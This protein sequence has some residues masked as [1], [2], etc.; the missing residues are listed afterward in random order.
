MH[1]LLAPKVSMILFA[2]LRGSWWSLEPYEVA[3][4]RH[5]SSVLQMKNTSDVQTDGAVGY[6]AVSWN[7]LND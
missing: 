2:T 6:F 4:D 5:L 3:L 1:G 7:C